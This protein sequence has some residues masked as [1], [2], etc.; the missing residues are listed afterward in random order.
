MPVPDP[1]I[2]EIEPPEPSLPAYEE[3]VDKTIDPAFPD[4][5]LLVNKFK[6]PEFEPTPVRKV[7]VPLFP[8]KLDPPSSCNTPPSPPTDDPLNIVTD[9]PGEYSEP[10]PP[11]T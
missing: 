6:D 8:L 5:E 10:S 3:P 11:N 2:T 7:I 9:P 4:R 1:A